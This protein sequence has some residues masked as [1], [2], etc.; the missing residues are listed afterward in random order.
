MVRCS[1]DLNSVGLFIPFKVVVV[2]WVLS[3]PGCNG[4][5]S[6]HSIQG[7]NVDFLVFKIKVFFGVVSFLHVQGHKIQV[8]ISFNLPAF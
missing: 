2:L 5:H 8:K 3:L 6:T 4:S 7:V 1:K